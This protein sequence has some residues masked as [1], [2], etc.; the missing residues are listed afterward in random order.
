MGGRS[1]EIKQRDNVGFYRP[2]RSERLGFTAAADDGTSDLRNPEL[3]SSGHNHPM[4]L[5]SKP[6]DQRGAKSLFGTHPTTIAVR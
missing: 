2:V 6:P 1:G 5:D 3:R 4:A